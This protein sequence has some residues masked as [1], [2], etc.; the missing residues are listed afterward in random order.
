[1]TVRAIKWIENHDI[2]SSA[3]DQIKAVC[4][5]P[6]VTPHVAIMPDV[7]AGYG[8]TIG[9]V[10]PTL[11]SVIPNA[12]GVDIGCGVSAMQLPINVH[13]IEN[14]DEFWP[15]WA[16]EVRRSVPVGF[17]WHEQPIS[18]QD[19]GL[20]GELRASH[21]NHLLEERA[22]LQ[23]GTL[24]GGNH[25]LEAA[26]DEDGYIWL[27]VHSGSRRLGLEIAQYYHAEAIKSKLAR[28]LDVAPDL[29]SLLL[30]EEQGQNYL[31][32]HDFAVD[33]A[34]RSRALMLQAMRGLFSFENLTDEIIDIPHN[35]VAPMKIDG[36]TH[37]VH[38]KGATFAGEGV[39]GVVPGSMG[40]ASYIVRGK[41]NPDSFSSCSHGAGRRLGRGAAKRTITT[42]EF[43][44]SLEGT[45]STADA[46]L[47]DEAPD[48]YKSIDDVME[49]QRDLVDIVH[50]LRPIV[51]I[52]GGG[53]DE[54]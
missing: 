7:H 52:K 50:R 17:K 1:M 34:I 51:T 47:L 31:A 35:Y 41:G 3:W 6:E 21:L 49:K 13:D 2:E 8:V 14:P 37:L 54:G 30:T 29:A 4:A 33:Y 42:E 26:H 10:V 43:A 28:H 48:A 5:H 39:L 12:V 36:A 45:Y 38:R 32:D 46:K 40:T 19:V 25:F 18:L 9:S 16:G 23:V 44:K 24:G 53:R 11:A 22:P 15:E 27:L 20:R